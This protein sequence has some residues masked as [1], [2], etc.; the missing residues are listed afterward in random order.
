LNT[1]VSVWEVGVT[2]LFV[3]FILI[4]IVIIMLDEGKFGILINIKYH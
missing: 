4:F 1:D 2:K 3:N